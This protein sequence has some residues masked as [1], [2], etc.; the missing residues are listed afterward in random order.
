[1]ATY[2]KVWN[3]YFREKEFS[4]SLDD[5]SVSEDWKWQCSIPAIVVETV[6]KDGKTFPGDQ[7]Y[8][9]GDEL[10]LGEG[11]AA[12]RVLQNQRIGLESRYAWEESKDSEPREP[13]PVTFNCKLH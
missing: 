6:E 2:D 8:N 7:W 9:D 12:M 5:L 3:V 13:V 10:D 1:M 4:L 11:R